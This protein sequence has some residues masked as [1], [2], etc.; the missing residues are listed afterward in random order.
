MNRS[1]AKIASIGHSFDGSLTCRLT[2]PPE[3]IPGAGQAALAL[4]TTI[5]SLQRSTLFPVQVF[6][7]GFRCLAPTDERWQPGDRVDILS[8]IGTGF[9]V[10][11]ESRRWFLIAF[12]T[13]PHYLMPLLDAA[14]QTDSSVALYSSDQLHGLPADIEILTEAEMGFEWADYAAI[15][16][17]VYYLDRLRKSFGRFADFP[18]PCP[19]QVLFIDELAC[20]FGGCLSCGLATQDHWALRCQQGPVFN[21]E[22]LRV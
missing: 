9:Q 12:Q 5:R 2:C 19:T 4:N 16:L 14:D 1:Q 21:W 22:Q 11:T 6:E 18:V 7:D 17:P 10:P 3:A 13:K 20:G 15:S 8:P